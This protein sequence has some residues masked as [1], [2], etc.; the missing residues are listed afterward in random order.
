MSK[1]HVSLELSILDH[2]ELNTSLWEII[3]LQMIFK[4]I[5]FDLGLF[6]L[7]FLCPESS[8]KRWVYKY[9]KINNSS[10]LQSS[11]HAWASRNHHGVN[12]LL[13]LF[14]ESFMCAKVCRASVGIL[15][16]ECFFSSIDGTVC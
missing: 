4:M 3:I 15:E 11:T 13:I 6:I 16:I 2:L 8:G 5:V 1:S 14:T 12:G 9:F 7:A 10:I